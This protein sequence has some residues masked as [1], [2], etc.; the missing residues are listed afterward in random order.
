[1][2]TFGFMPFHVWTNTHLYWHPTVLTTQLTKPFEVP[3]KWTELENDLRRGTKL[4]PITWECQALVRLSAERLKSQS[5]FDFSIYIRTVQNH[6][7][8]NC[9]AKG[10]LFRRKFRITFNCDYVSIKQH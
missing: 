10:V 2:H 8:M 1:M 9:F 7:E 3:S 4:M 6:S 5:I